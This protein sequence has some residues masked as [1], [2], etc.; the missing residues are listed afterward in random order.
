MEAVKITNQ[1]F[2][3]DKK[4]NANTL[5]VD[6]E[7]YNALVD[8]VAAIDSGEMEIFTGVVSFAKAATHYIAVTLT[9]NQAITEKVETKKLGGYAELTLYG[10]GSHA[11]TFPVSWVATPSSSAYD[12]TLGVVNKIG[13]YYDGYYVYYTITP[14]V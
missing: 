2:R 6:A 1:N 5:Y 9:T 3:K 13:C 4:K 12:T 8:D 10:D 7:F 11:P 14:I